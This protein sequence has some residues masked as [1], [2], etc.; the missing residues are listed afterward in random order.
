MLPQID[1]VQCHTQTH[2]QLKNCLYCICVCSRAPHCMTLFQNEQD[3]TPRAP[4]KRQFIIE[5][6]PGLQDTKPLIAA[7][8]TERRCFSKFILESNVTS[9]ISGSSDSISTVPQ[10]VNGGDRGCILLDLK[11]IIVLVLL[12]FNFI[13]Y[14]PH[15]SRTLPWSRIRD[16]AT[17]T[18]TPGDGT[19]VNE[20]ES[21]AITDQ[22]I[23][24]NGKQLRGVQK[25]H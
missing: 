18:L 14:M 19:T 15:H 10:I 12:A 16:S 24:L 13:P 21:S 17:I 5:Y 23:L 2:L 11:T 7:L 1:D 6:S 22:L 9:N 25:E 4:S 8:E 20:V 3:K